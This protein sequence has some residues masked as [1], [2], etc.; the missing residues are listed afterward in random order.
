M[1]AASTLE[2]HPGLLAL[3]ARRLRE[4]LPVL[5]IST[6]LLAVCLGAFAWKGIYF[7]IDGVA[8][9][10][11]MYLLSAA[12]V[13]VAGAIWRLWRDKPA[14]PTRYLAERYLLDPARR[15]VLIG[16]LPGLV[17]LCGFMPFFSTLKAAI[18]LYAT[19]DWDSTFIA[20]ERSLLLGHDAWQ[21]LQPVLGH[22]KI[23]AALAALY[24]LWILICYPGTVLFLFAPIDNRLRRR[25]L[26][27]FVLAW[28]LIGGVMAMLFAS[29]GPCFVG[30]LAGI[31][32][33]DAQMAYLR[34]ANAQVPVLTL[35]V[36]DLLLARFHAAENG[37]GS[38]ISA[39]PSMHIAMC[40]LFYL[41]I[42]KIDPRFGRAAMAFGVVI[43]ISSVHLAYH[44]ALDGV[45]SAIAVG[46]IW[47][48]SGALI[49][50][51]D[52]RLS[53]YPTLRTNTVPA[54]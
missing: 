16:A 12:I 51:W 19:Y 48:A 24:H 17:I 35:D 8:Q 18:P 39:M 27:G 54:E 30:P 37:L 41:G 53:A 38:G 33:F 5:L 52:A 1:T 15:E 29:Y 6:V 44:Y 21:L 3:S 34:A 4:D 47:K 25:F 40:T 31:H 9:N 13:L 20:W 7:G 10:S 32:D 43:W 42:R 50:W 2:R 45:V 26:L 14:R 36:Q 22:P 11:R 28:S 23:T 49:D 46:L